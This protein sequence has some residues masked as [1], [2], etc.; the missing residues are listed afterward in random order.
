MEIKIFNIYFKNIT[1]PTIFII[2]FYEFFIKFFNVFFHLEP[3]TGNI[4]NIA[5]TY[6]LL[7]S[8]YCKYDD[9][10]LLPYFSMYL[11]FASAYLC[12]A[13]HIPPL[14]AFSIINKISVS[15]NS[16]DFIFVFFK[17]VCHANQG[18]DIK[19]AEWSSYISINLFLKFSNISASNK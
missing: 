3:S 8:K 5:H 11:L 4:S 13:W 18:A 9:S 6:R 12:I 10:L 15:V 19:W 14:I 17:H 1:F 16:S 7:R 2:V